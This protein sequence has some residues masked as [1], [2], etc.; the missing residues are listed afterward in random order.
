MIDAPPAPPFPA[1]R[2]GGTILS[3]VN[4]DT[5]WSYRSISLSS[6]FV[7]GACQVARPCEN[8]ISRTPKK[9]SISINQIPQFQPR[10]SQ[11]T[12]KSRGYC[13]WPAQSA[14]ADPAASARHRFALCHY[15]VDFAQLAFSSFLHGP[16]QGLDHVA[17]QSEPNLVEY[18]VNKT[19]SR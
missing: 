1:K 9:T 3:C 4:S 5:T 13:G 18:R 15:D 7:R 2:S 8:C 6:S 12:S 16:N 11:K 10:A 17:G 14:D 19:C